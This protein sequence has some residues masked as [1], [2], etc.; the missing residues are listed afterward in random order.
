[1]DRLM[2]FPT[3]TYIGFQSIVLFPSPHALYFLSNLVS[4]HPE[5]SKGPA[6]WNQCA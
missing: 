2:D 1:M 5:P 4:P 3:A 6:P